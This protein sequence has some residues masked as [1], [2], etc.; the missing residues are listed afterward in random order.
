MGVSYVSE[1][2]YHSLTDIKVFRCHH[3]DR[4]EYFLLGRLPYS[5]LHYWRTNDS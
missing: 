4:L 1:G 3:T 5:E 2:Q